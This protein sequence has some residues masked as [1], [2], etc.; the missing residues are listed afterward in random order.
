MVLD[1]RAKVLTKVRTSR[2]T[3]II[4][5]LILVC[6][7]A[8]PLILWRVQSIEVKIDNKTVHITTFSGTVGGALAHAGLH[9]YPEDRVFPARDT[10]IHPG[11]EIEVQRSVPIKLNVDG[12]II[13]TRS[14]GDNVGDALNSL[15]RRFGLSLKPT[16]EVNVARSRA[17][18]P[19]MEIDV[20]RAVALD[21]T[22]DGR[23]WVA[24]LA[25]RTVAAALKKLGL[26]LGPLDKVSLPLN[27]IIRAGDHLT[28]V[29]VTQKKETIRT[30][31]PYQ[32]VTQ[33]ANFPVGFPDRLV[34]SG[35][36][37]L[38]E[39]TVQ[40]TLAD[41]KEVSSKVLAQR[42]IRPP[43]N[44]VI[45]RGA[46]T[47]VSRGGRVINFRKA[48]IMRATAY[49]QLNPD[50]A[51]GAPARWGVVA[52]DPGVIPLGTR[53]YVEGYGDAQALD[54]GADIKGNR[55]DLYMD[56]PQAAEAW[57]VRSVVV[58]VK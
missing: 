28:L 30:A 49:S 21:V 53:L 34:T 12:Q 27:H 5:S 3:Q 26:T 56:T 36:N 41:G 17:L 48:Y 32:V 4:L 16:D 8:V 7:L 18:S 29:R 6:V 14:A 25:P 52:V 19:G 35:A 22:A 55:I 13:F 47:S 9:I 39:Q 20:R 57:G 33:P 10:P 45:S 43:V 15:S 23:Q 31:V 44:E 50:T 1:L 58:Y 46:E 11:L 2:L 42:V 40:V 37:G 54:T 51:T 24:N 38:E